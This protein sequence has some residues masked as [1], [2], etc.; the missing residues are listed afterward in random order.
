LERVST[1]ATEKINL[2]DSLPTLGNVSVDC[3]SLGIQM[4]ASKIKQSGEYIYL[5]A[6]SQ[7]NGT[8]AEETAKALAD[9]ICQ[10]RQSVNSSK[11]V[12]GSQ[13]VFH[14]LLPIP[15]QNNINIQ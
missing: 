12:K 13:G 10:L 8:M 15:I 5:Y 9:L 14:L 11:L 7:Q 2:S 1:L 4:S 6:L 3:T